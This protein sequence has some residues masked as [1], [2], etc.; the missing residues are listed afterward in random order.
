MFEQ[1]IV[2]LPP[3][4]VTF[5]FGGVF[6]G[7]RFPRV[8]FFTWLA[9]L[10]KILTIDNLRKQNFIVVNWCCMW[11]RVG[12][13]QIISYSIARLRMP[14]G[15]LSLTFMG[16]V[17]YASKVRGSLRMLERAARF[18][19]K[20]SHVEDDSSSCLIWCIQRERNYRSFDD[21]ERSVVDLKAFFFKTLY[22]W[23]AD[24]DCLHI[25]KILITYQKLRVFLEQ[26]NSKH[27][28]IYVSNRMVFC[29][30]K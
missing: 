25:S 20:V 12:N 29:K 17:G 16:K 24:S 5:S 15:V 23:T 3:I 6:G 14:F 2:P 4:I 28:C 9:T 7:I 10:G 13:P 22:Q 8:V 30:V 26:K 19:S 21:W 27:I 1:F 11:K 18:F